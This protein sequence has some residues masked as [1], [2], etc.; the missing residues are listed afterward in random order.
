M[1]D[2]LALAG[3]CQQ[4]FGTCLR[5]VLFRSGHLSQV[6]GVELADGMTAVLKIRPYELSLAAL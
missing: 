3:V 6:V 5:A 1:L 2:D 4:L